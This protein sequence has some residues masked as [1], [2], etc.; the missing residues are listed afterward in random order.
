M[1]QMTEGTGRARV[2]VIGPG[3]AGLTSAKHLLQ[4]GLDPI[5]LEQ[6]DDLG[7]QWHT[8]AP[9]SG[10]WP[11]MR[12]NTSRTTTAFSDFPLAPSVAMFPRAE[13]VHAYLREY[14]AHFGVRNGF[15]PGPGWRRSHAHPEAGT[16]AGSRTASNARSAS[17]VLS[18]P[19]VGIGSLGT[20]PRPGSR[21]RGRGTRQALIRLLGA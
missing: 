19:A 3:P 11:G 10:V 4:E 18:W 15:E 7:G 20:R 21:A 6:S 1:L 5:V 8:S 17:P 14:A 13:D 16:F 9:H 12:T 2:A